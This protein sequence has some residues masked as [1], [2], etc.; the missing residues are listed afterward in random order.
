L[1]PVSPA[2]WAAARASARAA[3]AARWSVARR[4]AAARAWVWLLALVGVCL[5]VALW[6][7]V[8]AA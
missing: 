7:A 3:A 4:R 8:L 1:V 6:A 2:R 5:A